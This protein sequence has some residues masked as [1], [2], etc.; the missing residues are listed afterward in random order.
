MKFNAKNFRKLRKLQKLS[1]KEVAQKTGIGWQTIWAWENEKRVPSE[2]KIRM[3]GHS[4]KI[5]LN[6][7]SDLDPEPEISDCNFSEIGKSWLSFIDGDISKR[8]E[9][10]NDFINKIN[11]IDNDLNKA[12]ILINALL[13]SMSSMLY[14]KDSNL[15]YIIVNKAFLKNLSLNKTYKSRGKNDTDFFPAIEAKLNTQQDQEVLNTGTAIIDK[16]GFIPG[17]RK[18]RWGLISKMPIFDSG[19]KITGL[20]GTYIDITERKNEEEKSKLL[21]TALNDVNYTF[22]LLTASRDKTLFLSKSVEK[23]YG[24]PLE[25]FYNEKDF[26]LND[27]LHPDDLEKELKNRK[28]KP[29]PNKREFRII[30]ADGEVRFI[31]E[32]VYS[33]DNYSLGIECDIT[34]QK[35]IDEIRELLKINVEALTDALVIID[36]DTFKY[37]Y[38]NEAATKLSG[39][40]LSTLYKE[41]HLFWRENCV[42]K[43]YLD[44]F[45]R[46]WSK[47]NFPHRFEYKMICAD[48][49]K[50]WVET[51]INYKQFRGK[52]CLVGI[53]RDITT[54]KQM[55]STYEIM[56]KSI[57]NMADGFAV[58][59]RETNQYLYMNK[60]VEDIIGYPLSTFYK[61]GYAFWHENCLHPDSL[62]EYDEMKSATLWP[63][64]IEYKVI[65]ASGNTLWL[66]G[67]L[68]SNE[69]LGRNCI[70]STIRD[71]TVRKKGENIVKLMENIISTSNEIIWLIDE[72]IKKM[73]YVSKSVF[74]IY[75][76]PCER[77]YEPD[78]VAF[79]F[80]E[81]LHPDY[82]KSIFGL[83]DVDNLSTVK[84]Y[85]IITSDGKEKFMETT[86]IIYE[87]NNNTYTAY[88][89]RNVAK[90][91]SNCY[92]FDQD[93]IVSECSKLQKN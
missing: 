9:I 49:E 31:Q 79:W 16:E 17:T 2:A 83:S 92:C 72:T 25:K 5:P 10:K 88:I 47:K 38:L 77:F 41:G 39:Y 42:E 1:M 76:Y 45:I 91:H 23:V 50:K 78:G 54:Q 43:E 36:I 22:W 3:L 81:C 75:G 21:E 35:K 46:S 69:Y 33:G 4:L 8:I 29:F 63:K 19:R 34:E 74:R 27:C 86:R 15:K 55:E 90:F 70:I 93:D 66:E 30:R 12:T 14:V 67:V 24:Y 28:L 51:S 58:L 62:D 48:G 65:N 57:E 13:S 68:N 71:I 26:W 82:N 11:R 85:K 32:F 18:K 20:I 44:I 56:E 73:I 40:P 6:E 64:K 84:H 52:N 60:A 61:N 80:N 37:L 53:L 59:D 7:I 87:E 89:E